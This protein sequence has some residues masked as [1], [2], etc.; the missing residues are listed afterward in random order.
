MTKKWI[1]SGIPRNDGGL[2]CFVLAALCDDEYKARDDH[3]KSWF[4]IKAIQ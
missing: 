3:I 2:D 1:A 4:L